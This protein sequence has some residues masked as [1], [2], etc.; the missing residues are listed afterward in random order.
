MNV[1]SP[2]LLSAKERHTLPA[3]VPAKQDSAKRL[4]PLTLKYNF[5]QSFDQ[6]STFAKGLRVRLMQ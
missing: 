3:A 1:Q 2:D 6:A 5:E 4:M